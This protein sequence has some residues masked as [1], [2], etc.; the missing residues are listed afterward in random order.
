MAE[1][2]PEDPTVVREGELEGGRMPL[3][4]HLRELRTRLRNAIIAL[5]VGFLLALNFSQ[6]LFVFL[7]RPL[8]GVWNGLE[9]S[10]PLGTRSLYFNSL[11]EPFWTYF[12][13]SFWAGIFI[14][15]P[16]IFQQVWNFIAPGLYK[17]ERRYGV[18]FGIFSAL[19]FVGGASFCYFVVLPTVYEFL[20][21]YANQNLAEMSRAVGESQVTY[22]LSEAI[23]LQPLLSMQEYLS[24]SKKLLLGFGLIFELPLLIFFLAITGV[25]THRSLWKFNRWAIVLS[26]VIG[27]ILTPP[28]IYSQLLMSVPLIVLYNL[29]IVIAWVVT[30]RRER[31][32]PAAAA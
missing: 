6:E 31:K 20:L 1:K 23:A 12:S 9:A 24:F 18:F 32:T 2:N 11:V 27:A 25:V 17:S 7:V 5:I 15:S 26:F 13:I 19:F 8:V 21:G 22:N 16:F 29:S 10:A 4:E 30:V 28:E 3:M 14:A